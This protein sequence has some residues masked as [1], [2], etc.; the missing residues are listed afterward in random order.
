[1]F[2]FALCVLVLISY[3]NHCR[4]SEPHASWIL[5]PFLGCWG[6]GVAPPQDRAPKRTSSEAPL[7]DTTLVHI[8]LEICQ[9][10]PD[11]I[12][13]WFPPKRC[14]CGDQFGPFQ[15]PRCNASV[16]TKPEFSS[17]GDVASCI[18]STVAFF[19]LFSN[20]FSTFLR[21]SQCSTAGFKK[22]RAFVSVTHGTRS[23]K[24]N[25]FLMSV[26]ALICVRDERH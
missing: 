4:K 11:N 1:M 19:L 10:A 17:S 26:L 5:D 16:S 8:L 23:I 12:Q 24:L 21:L 6:R 22:H 18:L 20:L 3:L 15:T 9:Q 2:F 25:S 14:F 7:K 13:V